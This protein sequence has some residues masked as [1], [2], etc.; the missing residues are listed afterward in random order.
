MGHTLLMGRRTYESVG[1][2]L[3]GRR[4]IVVASRP[5]TGVEIVSVPEEALVMLAPTETLFVTGGARLFEEFLPRA[6][7][8]Y[9]TRVDLA[10]EGDTFFPP[11][12]H[13]LTGPYRLLQR[14]EHA[15]FTFE[16]Y[17]R[18]VAEAGE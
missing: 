6:D 2:P 12:E 7:F 15:G 17:E 3:S 10:P 1:R 4:T 5:I 16:D 18:E 13:L 8:L 11:F 9:L 14:E